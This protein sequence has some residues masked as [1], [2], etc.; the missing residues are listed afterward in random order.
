MTMRLSWAAACA[1]GLLLLGGMLVIEEIPV[2]AQ[3][4]LRAALTFHAGFDNGVNAVHAAG[5]RTLYSAPTFARRQEGTP[6]LPATGEVQ[7]ASGLGRFG[8]A[9]RFT[10][11]R[12]P[13]VFFKAQRNVPYAKTNW[14]GT[15]SFWLS[16]D[17]AGELDPGFC[18]PV[19][20]TPHAWNN[21]AFFVEFEKTATA[22]PFRLGV[23]ADLNV[24]N[25]TNRRFEDIPGPERPLVT[26][27]QPPF[28]KGKWTHVAFTFDRFN[29]G[30]P[31]GVAR[32]YLDGQPA[33]ALTARR[34][35]F[36]WDP[37]QA[38]INIGAGYV[39]MFD[40]LSVFGRVLSDAE[41]KALHALPTGVAGLLP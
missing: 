14:A 11:R 13:S 38:A 24:W 34:Q 17:P 31:D 2:Q 28:G 23:Y 35:T 32:L 10:A 26:V 33:G 1:A 27:E 40:E 6:G 36:T 22:T 12:H 29:T 21:A 9:L 41:I 19:Q 18:D 39:G 20:I 25:P 37:A 8:D 30:E 7:V 3:A 4:G 5:D 16:V 15:V